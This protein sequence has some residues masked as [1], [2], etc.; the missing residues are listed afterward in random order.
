[1]TTPDSL[2]ATVANRLPSLGHDAVP[3]WVGRRLSRQ[4]RMANTSALESHGERTGHCDEDA[5][6]A[7]LDHDDW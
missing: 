5:L 7:L 6:N 2:L 4:R 1:M 3:A